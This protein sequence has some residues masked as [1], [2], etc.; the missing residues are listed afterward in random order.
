MARINIILLTCFILL[1]SLSAQYY[2]E[3][4]KYCPT[5]VAIYGICSPELV[6]NWLVNK[7]TAPIIKSPQAVIP[8]ETSAQTKVSPIVIFIADTVKPKPQEVC[9]YTIG[10]KEKCKGIGLTGNTRPQHLNCWYELSGKERCLDVVMANVLAMSIQAEHQ[11]EAEH[12]PEVWY[13][14][15]IW[16]VS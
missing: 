15:R 11:K 5:I 10:G 13:E 12:Q 14:N 9:W 1:G 7:D 6:S 8:A 16:M 2:D 4:E 3:Y